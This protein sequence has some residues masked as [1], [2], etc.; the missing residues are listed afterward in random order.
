MIKKFRT[1]I[2]LYAAE[3]RKLKEMA[4]REGSTAAEQIREAIAAYVA[5]APARPL[6]RSLAAGSSEN[7]E[8]SENAEDL[9]RGFGRR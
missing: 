7:G 4:D 3:Y 1:T 5:H 6:P 2:Y 9:L 8:I